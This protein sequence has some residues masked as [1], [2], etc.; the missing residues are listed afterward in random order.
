VHHKD[1]ETK[2]IHSSSFSVNS[3]IFLPH[4][5][6]K[7]VNDSRMVKSDKHPPIEVAPAEQ[8]VAG[9]LLVKRWLAGNEMKF[10][11]FLGNY[12]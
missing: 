10:D 2:E 11:I 8:F 5:P 1:A 12:S 4:K 9:D 3:C 7:E 6:S